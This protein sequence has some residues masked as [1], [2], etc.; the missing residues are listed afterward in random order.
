[1]A[2]EGW[3]DVFQTFLSSSV[4]EG[5]AVDT[6][7]ILPGITSYFV[8]SFDGDAFQFSFPL[9]SSRDL[10]SEIGLDPSGSDGAVC[11]I[12]EQ[13]KEHAERIPDLGPLYGRGSQFSLR[14]RDIIEPYTIIHSDDAIGSHLWKADARNYCDRR[15]VHLVIRGALA[16]HGKNP[17]TDSRSIITALS[18]LAGAI[19]ALIHR[20]PLHPLESAWH[21]SLD[22]KQARA[23]FPEQGLVSF[24]GDGSRLARTLTRHR[25]FS[26]V[27]GPKEGVNMPFRCPEE[28][29]PAE[30]ELPSSN[31]IVTG[32]G[33]R[34]KD[35]L[36]IAG[37]N[38]Q[39]KS[40]FLEGILAGMD[41]HALH[42][43]RE[44]VVTVRGAGVAE[45]TPMSLAGADISMFFHALPPGISGTVKGASGMGSGSM[46]M[47]HQ[48]QTA[49]ARHAPLLIID[50][51]RAAPNLLVRSCLQKEEITPLAEILAHERGTMGDTALVFAACAM[52]TLIA[53]ADRIMVL[54]RHEASAIDPGV[55]RRML[56]ESLMKNAKKLL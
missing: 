32:L 14:C 16:S 19:S 52:D 41:D 35:I 29:G 10:L 36:A 53:Q 48:I 17:R 44:Q 34:K 9:L 55:F 42:D 40:T 50:E 11:H 38:A 46:T 31:Q 23:A 3:D 49:I 18:D 56:A 21:V 1:M 45:S 37:S 39:G 43:G 26:R 4:R 12:I 28:L 8:R 33:I 13:I 5:S 54:D 2:G 20:I 15:G 47:A 24:V 6:L 25:C 7:N 27:A 30:L 22:Q 51:D